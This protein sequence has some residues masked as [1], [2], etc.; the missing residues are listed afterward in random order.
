VVKP[1]LTTR[2][3]LILKHR[4]GFNHNTDI[5]M[6]GEI[7]DAETAKIAVRAA[8]TGH[9]VLSTMHTRD[10]KGAVYRLHE[11]GVDWIE[12][13]QTLI[14]VTAQRLVEL[15]CPF[16][17]EHCSP[18]CYAIGRWKR[19]SVF[20]LLSGRNLTSMMKAAKGEKTV[21]NYPLLKNVIRKGIALGYI[22]ESE[23]ERLVYEETT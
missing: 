11:F 16:C 19:A 1:K 8:L 17:T 5:I 13:E 9:L 14:A 18:H 4:L 7:R 23:Y 12:V 21:A 20:E 10:A 3:T 2:K 22:K 6:V 15:T